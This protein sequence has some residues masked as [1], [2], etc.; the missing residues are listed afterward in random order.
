[1]GNVPIPR[2]FQAGELET[3][4]YLQTLSAALNFLLKPP[5]CR[6]STNTAN[7]V[8]SSTYI[9]IPFTGTEWNTDN[10]WSAGNPLRI[11]V[12]TP[13]RYLCVGTIDWH[14]NPD[15]QLRLAQVFKNGSQGT[16]EVDVRSAVQQVWN[17]K[18]QVVQSYQCVA[19]DYL[20]LA[21]YQSSGA[22]LAIDSAHLEVL[23]VS[24]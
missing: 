11:T 9:Q 16:N 4:A 14:V 22:P 1:M 7:T 15:N 18:H 6:A 19:G 24:Q 8:G 13:G 2:T 12:Q 23:W 17:T 3:G 20:S 10:M 21:G 5:A